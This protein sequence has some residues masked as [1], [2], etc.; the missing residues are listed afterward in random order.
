MGLGLLQPRMYVKAQNITVHP[1]EQGSGR[2]T[3]L[4]TGSFPFSI[5]HDISAHSP[6]KIRFSSSKEEYSERNTGLLI[7]R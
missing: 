7:D 4:R 2:K 1:S 6:R 3:A 5:H